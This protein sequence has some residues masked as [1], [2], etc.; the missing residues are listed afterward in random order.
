[1]S[2]EKQPVRFR[3]RFPK[4][5]PNIAVS[6]GLAR[7]RRLSGH[8]S[9]NEQEKQPESQEP[10]TP[11]LPATPRQLIESVL[12]PK[13]TQQDSDTSTKPVQLDDLTPSLFISQ[14]VPS[15]LT[16]RQAISSVSQPSTP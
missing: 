8:Y 15:P 10:S 14:S 1:M 5:Q 16:F 9:S 6:S 7:I 4:A 2:E 12:S 11:A 13:Q 3:S